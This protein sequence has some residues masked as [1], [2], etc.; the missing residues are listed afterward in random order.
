MPAPSNPINGTEV[1]S[2]ILSTEL[3]NAFKQLVS[4]EAPARGIQKRF[5]S[6]QT[7][8]QFLKPLKNSDLNDIDN[9]LT[10]QLNEYIEKHGKLS[11][12]NQR[13]W[14]DFEEVIKK[15]KF[16]RS[17]LTDDESKAVFDEV[18]KATDFL[19]KRKVL[20][21]AL[22]EGKGNQQAIQ[23]EL[24]ILKRFIQEDYGRLVSWGLSTFAAKSLK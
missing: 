6:G 1:N 13:L 10:K 21:K 4:N 16:I 9:V 15:R 14:N 3:D 18:D 8:K 19:E 5:F 23:D 24:I 22:K 7:F 11:D 20:Q 12:A 2:K 17:S